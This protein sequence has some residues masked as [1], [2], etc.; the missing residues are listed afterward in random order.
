MGTIGWRKRQ[1]AQVRE[2]GR[3]VIIAKITRALRNLHKLPSLILAIPLVL[4]IRLLRPW[5]LVRWGHM[6]SSR[7]GHFAGNTE[8]YLCE[9]DVGINVPLRR[10]VD[11]F[12]ME[13]TICNDQLARMWRR[14]LRVVPA[15]ILSPVSQMNRFFPGGTIHEIGDNTQHDRDVH[16][17]LDRI[18]P[19]LSF[20]AEEE[21][22]GRT[23]L[24]QMGIPAGA[25]FVCLIVRDSAY[26]DSHVPGGI[27]S[28]HNYRDSDIQNYV[29]AAEQ[30]AHRG[31]SVLRMG[32]KVRE[33][34]KT[35]HPKVIDYATNGMRTDF[36]DVFLGAKCTFCI[37]VGTGFDA[38]AH[39][40][41]RPV[42]Y[43]NMV[44]IGY[45]FT[46]RHQ[47]L[48][49]FKH[50]FTSSLPRQLSLAEVFG[51]GL[52][53]CTETTGYE[54]EGVRLIENTPEEIRDVIL[55]MEARLQSVWQPDDDDEI[56][57]ERFWS[58]F[59]ATESVDVP[60][61]PLHGEIRARVGAAF[62]RENRGWLL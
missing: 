42:V 40:F 44:P 17:L 9:R 14:V 60:R 12:F 24:R 7:L 29:L 22:L 59:P 13:R 15:W 23:R 5:L 39:A 41:R 26:L 58:I 51:C 43:V 53:F 27:W 61:A 2:G 50:H 45:F 34:M 32:A 25:P 18:P 37:S 30:L 52:A 38:I 57:Q 1:R 47:C 10:H 21:A 48:G 20:T 28:Y 55:E 3:S 11:V 62:L 8:L 4:A 56:L 49:I 6:M 36:M 54:R 33:P 46:F 31:Y 35:A 19:H 16:N